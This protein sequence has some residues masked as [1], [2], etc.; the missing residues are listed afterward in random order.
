METGQ[1]KAFNNFMKSTGFAGTNT[2]PQVK[3]TPPLSQGDTARQF[4]GHYDMSNPRFQP[5]APGQMGPQPGSAKGMVTPNNGLVPGHKP[6]DTN[7][8]PTLTKQLDGMTDANLIGNQPYVAGSRPEVQDW[9]AVNVGPESD[10]RRP[11]HVAQSIPQ[12]GRLLPPFTGPIHKQAKTPDGPFPTVLERDTDK[13]KFETTVL[14][15]LNQKPM[16]GPGSSSVKKL[17]RMLAGNYKT[18]TYVFGAATVIST[19]V[20]MNKG[21]EW[22]FAALLF[23]ALTAY[24]LVNERRG[25]KQ[26]GRVGGPNAYAS[27]PTQREWDTSLSQT[28][29]PYNTEDADFN[30]YPKPEDTQT[31]IYTRLEAQG[32]DQ[33]NV[34]GP[35]S[36]YWYKRGPTPANRER[37]KT[38][39]LMR[40]ANMYN[41]NERDFDE[42]MARLDGEAPDQFYQAHPYMSISA[43]WDHHQQINDMDTMYGVSTAPGT[44]NRKWAYK[45]P[46]IQQAGA[47]TMHLKDPPPGFS[48]AI[49]SKVHPWL[50]PAGQVRGV[51]FDSDDYIENL[52]GEGVIDNM[53]MQT[54]VSS[55]D[56]GRLAADRQAEEEYYRSLFGKPAKDPDDLP[57]ALQP[58]KTSREG[59]A[60]QMEERKKKWAMQVAN[61]QN[62]TLKYVQGVQGYGYTVVPPHPNEPRQVPPMNYAQNPP[63]PMKYSPPNR[64]PAPNLHQRPQMDMVATDGPDVPEEKRA[65]NEFSSAFK[66][67]TP[68]EDTVKRLIQEAGK[69]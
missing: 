7:L 24:C 55:S 68:D 10:K 40:S 36:D 61:E 46:R 2:V 59:L 14:D 57:P 51:P 16:S 45:N 60:E 11:G 42:Y 48:H 44:Y 65:E 8:N 66:T 58:I 1:T 32:L 25:E 3:P 27:R 28:F 30:P 37:I 54:K 12:Q 62:R 29:Q 26:S 21:N 15:K 52:K 50:E 19:I 31:G 13:P 9:R 64:M 18:G 49:G 34:E 20:W 67:T 6:T 39:D 33:S 63:Y 38:K 47:K 23:A 43:F 41:M 35:R 22:S 5:Y 69:R 4:A 17:E 53:Q 56:A